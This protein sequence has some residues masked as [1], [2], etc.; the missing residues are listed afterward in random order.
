M[1]FRVT[2]NEYSRLLLPLVSVVHERVYPFIFRCVILHIYLNVH[3]R[4]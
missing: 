3:V 1:V 2:Q 4:L